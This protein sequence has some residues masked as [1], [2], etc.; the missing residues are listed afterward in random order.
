MAKISSREFNQDVGKAKRAAEEGPVIITD[1]GSPAFVL[2]TYEAFRKL[3]GASPS[4]LEL[5]DQKT[6][7][8]EDELFEA[9]RIAS[10]SIK[11]AMYS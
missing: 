2:M 1:R 4:I 8:P 10:G 6:A 3:A 7:Q 9:E 5:L 11:T